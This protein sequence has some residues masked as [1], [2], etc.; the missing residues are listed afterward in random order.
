L[1]GTLDASVQNTKTTYSNTQS[2]SQ[3]ALANNRRG[4]TQLSARGAEDLGGGLKA[5][6]MYE[7][8][9]TSATAAG[10]TNGIG[11]GGG[12]IYVGLEGGFGSIKLGAPNT[13]SLTAQASRQPIGTKLGSGFGASAILG[14]GH[15]REDNSFVY[16]TPN[17]AGF[18]AALGYKFAGAA[19]TAIAPAV[20][21]VPA[22]TDL[23]LNYANGPVKVGVSLYN[24]SLNVAGTGNKQ[25]NVY[26]QY[27]LGV[28]NLYLGLH[29]ETNTVT[30]TA[31]KSSGVNVAFK[32]P[33]G[34]VTVL[35]NF[36]KLNDKEATN[37]DKSVFALGAEYALSK[38]S[39]LYTRLVKE[40]NKNIAATV[41][42]IPAAGAAANTTGVQ[43]LLVGVQHNF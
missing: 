18:T 38:R 6:F 25:T 43:S 20:V 13:P 32:A 7:G 27:D 30:N 21:A 24:Q 41:G 39:T 26:A 36:A 31:S 9:F 1:F 10:T 3:N 23:G 22:K 17:F 16:S 40:S 4:T 11:N 5:L 19:N 37:L 28:A 42:A 35:G 14:T 15:V 34:A 12:E 2:F 8:D 29:N 33:I